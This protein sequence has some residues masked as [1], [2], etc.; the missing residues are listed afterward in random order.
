M[1]PCCAAGLG[2]GRLPRRKRRRPIDLM[3]RYEVI[4]GGCK[5]VS[6]T[7]VAGWSNVPVAIA[8]LRLTDDPE[9]TARWTAVRALR[10]WFDDDTR[11]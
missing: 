3:P 6:M 11:C 5:R 7:N 9:D 10:S 8:F 4:W 2:T 1:S